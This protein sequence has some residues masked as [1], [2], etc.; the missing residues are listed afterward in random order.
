MKST[1]IMFSWN[2]QGPNRATKNTAIKVNTKYDNIDIRRL[3]VSWCRNKYAL[4]INHT[5]PI[6][7]R[8]F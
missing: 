5:L 2:P 6:S 1:K 3:T 7:M 8:N 4:D